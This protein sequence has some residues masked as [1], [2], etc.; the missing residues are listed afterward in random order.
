MIKAGIGFRE[1]NIVQNGSFIKAYDAVEQ[2]YGLEW[3]YGTLLS[4]ENTIRLR[5]KKNFG[6]AERSRSG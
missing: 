3:E 6:N 5:N 1:E 4:T 2:L